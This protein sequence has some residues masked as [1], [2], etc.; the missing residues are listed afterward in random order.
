MN[1]RKAIWKQPAREGLEPA[2]AKIAKSCTEQAEKLIARALEAA[3]SLKTWA[4]R[5]RRVPELADVTAREI[6]VSKFRLVYQLKLFQ[7]G[8]LAFLQGARDFNCWWPGS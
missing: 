3:D 1:R 7:V 6:F 4:E 5:G 8:G 2:A